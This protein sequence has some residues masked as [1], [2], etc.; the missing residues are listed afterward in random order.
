M[1]E[2]VAEVEG[3]VVAVVAASVLETALSSARPT[4]T[5]RWRSGAPLQ[6]LR[7]KLPP[8]RLDPVPAS[9]D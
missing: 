7:L 4:S 3:V 2:D 1:E 8:L 5:P 6:A 9:M